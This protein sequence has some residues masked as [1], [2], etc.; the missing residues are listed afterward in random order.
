MA[1]SEVEDYEK[2]AQEVQT[3]FRHLKRAS[4]LHQ[5]KNYHQAPPALLCLLQKSFLPPPNSIFACWDI[6]EIQ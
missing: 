3:L 4:E 6:Q 5:M 2:L 1:V